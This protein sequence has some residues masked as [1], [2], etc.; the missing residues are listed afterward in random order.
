MSRNSDNGSN[1]PEFPDS[2]KR[3]EK[4]CEYRLSTSRGPM[5]K[6]VSSFD[7]KSDSD[8]H[9]K[10]SDIDRILSPLKTLEPT[11]TK[12]IDYKTKLVAFLD[13]LGFDDRVNQKKDDAKEMLKFFEEVVRIREHTKD[14]I[15]DM[16]FM[17]RVDMLALSDCIVL[18]CKE[19]RAKDFIQ[20]ISSIIYF[21]MDRDEPFLI[22]GGIA[23]GGVCVE[24]K[25]EAAQIIGPAYSDAYKL[26]EHVA[27]FPRVAVSH[28][29][30][31]I[32]VKNG[33]ADVVPTSFDGIRCLDFVKVLEDVP[34]FDKFCE[35]SIK[36]LENLHDQCDN[37]IGKANIKRKFAWILNHLRRTDIWM[38]TT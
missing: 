38:K 14:L 36:K 31:E 25:D 28:E 16:N 32:I 4:D 6:D 27:E 34:D 30:Y 26:Q 10:P 24:N 5:E 35:N 19:I 12:P 37:S 8:Q 23:Y 22:R 1:C 7:I 20:L 18:V 21:A 29:A 2:S 17:N 13:I 3:T 9:E 15:K 11:P 33:G